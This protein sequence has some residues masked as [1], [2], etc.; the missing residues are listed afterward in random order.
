MALPAESK[1][2]CH[3]CI[4]DLSD[5]DWIVYPVA[6]DGVLNY[7]PICNY[8]LKNLIHMRDRS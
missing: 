5:V 4:R 8:C 1:D 2:S 3:R 7:V 6:E